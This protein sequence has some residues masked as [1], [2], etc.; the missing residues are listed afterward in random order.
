MTDLQAGQELAIGSCFWRHRWTK[1]QEIERGEVYRSADKASVGTALTQ[2]RY[3]VNCNK[4][5]L[6]VERAML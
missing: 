3:C 1:W 2:S 5:E 4:K 6:R